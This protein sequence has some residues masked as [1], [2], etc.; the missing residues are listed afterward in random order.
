[1]FSLRQLLVLT[2]SPEQ[3]KSKDDTIPIT[4]PKSFMKNKH[5]H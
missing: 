5:C 4:K 3:P 2:I 1:M